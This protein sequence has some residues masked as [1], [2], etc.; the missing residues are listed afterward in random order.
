MVGDDLSA[1]ASGPTAPDPTTYHD[2]LSILKK[3]QIA[4]TIP[5]PVRRI[6]EMGAAGDVPDTLSRDLC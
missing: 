5:A 3:Y 2:A 1:I 4:D 6:L